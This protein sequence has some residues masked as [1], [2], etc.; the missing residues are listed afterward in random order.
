MKVPITAAAAIIP[1]FIFVIESGI[2]DIIPET[3]CAAKTNGIAEFAISA[4]FPP[5]KVPATV[6]AD[7]APIATFPLVPSSLILFVVFFVST[8]FTS[9]APA[10]ASIASDCL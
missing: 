3:P 7:S 10:F 9:T 2:I 8:V 6:S 5:A 4:T 1:P